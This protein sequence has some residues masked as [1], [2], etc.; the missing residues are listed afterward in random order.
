MSPITN[1]LVSR[2]RSF[3]KPAG[4]VAALVVAA[5]LLFQHSVHAAGMSPAAP[6]LNDNSVAPADLPR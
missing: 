4:A 5:G 1:Q 6:A 3:A 2:M